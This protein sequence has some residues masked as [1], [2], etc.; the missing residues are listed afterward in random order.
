MGGGGWLGGAEWDK[1]V[2]WVV[3]GGSR[4]G[5]GCLGFVVLFFLYSKYKGIFVFPFIFNC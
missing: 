2:V 5:L 4:V 3:V 1:G